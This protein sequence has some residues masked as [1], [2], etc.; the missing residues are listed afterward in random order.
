MSDSHAFA[1]S[2]ERFADLSDENFL[3]WKD[4][5]LGLLMA[6]GLFAHIEPLRIGVDASAADTEERKTAAAAEQQATRCGLDQG[7]AA[8]GR[9]DLD[10]R[11][12]ISS[13]ST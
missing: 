3:E 7:G 10:S 11:W 8:G 9:T 6:R 1:S 12:S 4:N 5:M 2:Q 13:A